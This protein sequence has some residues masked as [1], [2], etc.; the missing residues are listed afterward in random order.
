MIPFSCKIT[1]LS[2]VGGAVVFAQD[3]LAGNQHQIIHHIAGIAGVMDKNAE[4]GASDADV[5]QARIV[6]NDFG[7]GGARRRF[8]CHGNILSFLFKPVSRMGLTELL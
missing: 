4:A 2:R 1:S 5:I 6:E 7:I 3:R 8:I